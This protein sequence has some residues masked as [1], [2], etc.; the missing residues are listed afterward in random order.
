MLISHPEAFA[1]SD[2]LFGFKIGIQLIYSLVCQIGSIHAN[3]A[4]KSFYHR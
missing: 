1:T 2:V 3:M 4:L